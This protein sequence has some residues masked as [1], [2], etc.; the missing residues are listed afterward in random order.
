MALSAW[1]YFQRVTV[2][3]SFVIFWQYL[4]FFSAIS[5]SFKSK[6]NDPKTLVILRGL[7]YLKGNILQANFN[8]DFFIP[9]FV[10]PTKNAL[11]WKKVL[12][13]SEIWFQ[14]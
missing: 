10:I 4:E 1:T 9:N 11:F 7:K 12:K 8:I 5:K 13:N 6:K 2:E 14:F 3:L